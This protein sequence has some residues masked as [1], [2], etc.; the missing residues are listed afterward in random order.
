[1]SVAPIIFNTAT[2][3]YTVMDSFC[4]ARLMNEKLLKTN[5]CSENLFLINQLKFVRRAH[6]SSFGGCLVQVHPLRCLPSCTLILLGNASHLM[7][8]GNRPA[9]LLASV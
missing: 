7:L 5:P 8:T 3:C 9:V 2:F 4:C 6:G 1:M